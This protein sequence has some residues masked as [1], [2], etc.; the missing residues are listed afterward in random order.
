M[1]VNHKWLNETGSRNLLLEPAVYCPATKEFVPLRVCTDCDFL[2][3][4]VKEVDL[5]G[6]LCKY[7]GKKQTKK[8]IL[9]V[10]EPENVRNKVTCGNWAV[11]YQ[12][13]TPLGTGKQTNTAYFWTKKEAQEWVRKEKQKR[14]LCM[15]KNLAMHAINVA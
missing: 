5:P 3:R 10:G 11:E 14:I 4:V 6:V 1:K 8:N 9:S 15:E 2:E 7:K 12:V 13:S